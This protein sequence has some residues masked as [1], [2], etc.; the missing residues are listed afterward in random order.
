MVTPSLLRSH[1]LNVA[2]IKSTSQTV[3]KECVRVMGL[4]E[5]IGHKIQNDLS[6]SCSH[7]KLYQLTRE[8][9]DDANGQNE[10]SADKHAGLL[11][12]LPNNGA[13]LMSQSFVH[14]HL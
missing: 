12:I 1:A 11:A 2:S 5:E 7:F 8:N 4:S 10:K 14:H 6:I 9:W 3:I 13:F